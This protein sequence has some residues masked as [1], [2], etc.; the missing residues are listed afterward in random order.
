MTANIFSEGRVIYTEALQEKALILQE[1]IGSGA[2]SDVWLAVD[3]D[4]CKFAVKIPKTIMLNEDKF[5]SEYDVLSQIKAKQDEVGSLLNIPHFYKGHLEDSLQDVLIL[6]YIPLEK[7]WMGLSVASSAFVLSGLLE[8]TLQANRLFQLAYQL[9]IL[10]QDVKIE[11]FYWLENE[12]RFI[13]LDWNRCI[14]GGQNQQSYQAI[15]DSLIE[16]VYQVIAGVSSPEPLPPVD[17]IESSVWHPKVPRSIRRLLHYRFEN[18]LTF[19]AIREELTWQLEL[20]TTSFDPDFIERTVQKI[21]SD[22]SFSNHDKRERLLDLKREMLNRD[23]SGLDYDQSA[24]EIDLLVNEL[25]SS[26]ATVGSIQKIDMAR[27]LLTRLQPTKAN[28]ILLSIVE[29]TPSQSLDNKTLFKELFITHV[30]R[31]WF[32]KFDLVLSE[33]VDQVFRV[34]DELIDPRSILD[35]SEGLPFVCEQYDL[36]IAAQR[37]L[38]RAIQINEIGALKKKQAEINRF[39]EDEIAIIRKLPPDTK[40]LFRNQVPAWDEGAIMRHINAIEADKAKRKILDDIKEDIRQVL[41]SSEVYPFSKIERILQNTSEN[42]FYDQDLSL[43]KQLHIN[44]AH[45]NFHNS[46]KLLEHLQAFPSIKDQLIK[47][48]IDEIIKLSA[49]VLFAHD[50]QKVQRFFDLIPEYYVSGDE[51]LK[52]LYD[53][54]QFSFEANYEDLEDLKKCEELQVEPWA[55]SDSMKHLRVKNLKG[56]AQIANMQKNLIE[57]QY[58]IRNLLPEDE[59]NSLKTIY[60]SVI[61][62]LE[63]FDNEQNALSQQQDQV[64]SVD[65]ELS[66]L[67][68]EL[69]GNRRELE[70]IVAGAQVVQKE[71]ESV[72]GEFNAL[73]EKGVNIPTGL[74]NVS[75]LIGWLTTFIMQGLES[76]LIKAAEVCQAYLNQLNSN[77]LSFEVVKGWNDDLRRILSSS[78]QKLAYLDWV[79][80]IKQRNNAKSLEKMKRLSHE[81]GGFLYDFLWQKHVSLFGNKTSREEEYC[82][83]FNSGN[84]QLLTE[85]LDRHSPKSDIE[86]AEIDTWRAKIKF[87]RSLQ[88]FYRYDKEELGK[89]GPIIAEILQDFV[90]DNYDKLSKISN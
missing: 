55:V 37:L 47:F 46:V 4:G 78:E 19:E 6:E 35:K 28:E 61:N 15:L 82:Q 79:G 10:N 56:Y 34:F 25:I 33:E 88:K 77:S 39:K 24:H 40:Q 36:F 85:R 75:V 22:F 66:K 30:V 43:L 65:A 50:L 44:L 41:L 73:Q 49:Q 38:E 27:V 21:S 70:D 58:K 81:E 48:I 7:Q 84:L 67:T 68:N 16:F 45:Q 53:R 74:E 80:A 20:S 54:V 90:P 18:K 32:Q 17:N 69:S 8:A 3:A 59:L 83:L 71:A 87:I 9:D 62:Q 76:S 57:R 13:L 23:L 63:L 14:R 29:K 26:N 12:N 86:R 1:A 60:D 2:T 64:V 31:E 11:N 89:L 51:T 72:L 5:F 52:K 42:I